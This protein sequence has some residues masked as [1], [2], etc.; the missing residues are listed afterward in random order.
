MA[1]TQPH[2][3]LAEL[4]GAVWRYFAALAAIPRCSKNERAAGDYVISV[5]QEHGL[6]HSRDDAGN[7]VVSKPGSGAPAAGPPVVLQAHLDMVCEKN[8]GTDH[9]F[10]KQGIG[11]EIADGWLRARGTTLGA[12][13]GIAVAMMLAVLAADIPA[14]PVECLFTVDEESGLIG[15]Q[16]LDI[17]M[18][19]GRRLINLD[20]EEEGYLSIGC[21]GGLNTYVTIPVVRQSAAAGTDRYVLMISGLQGGHSGVNI[22]EGRGNA[23]VLAGRALEAALALPGVALAEIR[24]GDKH[25]A[26]PRECRIELSV[27][28]GAEPE[29]RAA[30]TRLTGDFRAEHAKIEPDLAMTLEAAAAPSG[31]NLVYADEAAQRVVNFLLAVPHGVLGMSEV[32]PGLVETSTNLAAIDRKNGTIEVLTSQRSPQESLIQWAAAKVTAAARLAGGDARKAEHYPGWPPNDQSPI[33]AQTVTTYESMYGK[34]PE[35]IAV[36]AGLEC[37]VIGSKIAGMDMVSFGPD[38]LGAHTPEERV[39]I[40]STDRTYEFLVALL[41]QL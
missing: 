38:I 40:A 39:S 19:T 34:A 3:A 8:M 17:R 35:V 10:A 20:S 23:L 15:A 22:H 37:G 36:H 18:L 26:I 7:I 11:L 12:D 6:A 27:A 1:N 41:A 32:V 25:N 33:L 13:N 5:A 16:N 28:A 21:A 31:D 29:L 4:E 30:V 14:P 2:D 9:D 24:G